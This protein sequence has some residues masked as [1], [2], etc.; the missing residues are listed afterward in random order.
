LS[1]YF[2]E[3]TDGNQQENVMRVGD[4][5]KHGVVTVPSSSD[6]VDA[7]NLMRQE[8]IGFL[9]VVE[10]GDAMRKPVGVLTD[11]DIVVQV[12]GRGVDPHKVTVADVM[13]PKPMVATEA[14]DLNEAMQGMRIAGIRRMPV[15]S[16]EGML[17][18][19]IAMDDVLDV[20]AGLVCDMCGTVR[21]EQRQERRVRAD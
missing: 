19:V 11:R 4:Y 5:C 7:A 8:H 13:S 9:V 20:V 10:S 17:T 18:G 21:N 3:S 14:D 15:L 2:H 12:V 6:V 1:E 16:R